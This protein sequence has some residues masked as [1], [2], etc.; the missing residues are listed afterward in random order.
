MMRKKSIDGLV[1]DQAGDKPP[2]FLG[3]IIT[4]GGEKQGEKWHMSDFMAVVPLFYKDLGTS[5]YK[6][7]F[8]KFYPLFYSPGALFGNF[9]L[10]ES[11]LILFIYAVSFAYSFSLSFQVL[12]LYRIIVQAISLDYFF[13]L[14]EAKFTG[15]NNLCLLIKLIPKHPGMQFSTPLKQLNNLSIYYYACYLIPLGRVY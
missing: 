4:A 3:H 14:G 12:C 8:I 11:L 5:P 7:F 2:A 1:L 10:V 6:P 15:K 9:G 13:G